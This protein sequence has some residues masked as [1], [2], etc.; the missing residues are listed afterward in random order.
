MA[1]AE[2]RKANQ[3]VYDE[4]SSF[5]TFTGDSDV[6]YDYQYNFRRSITIM[7]SSIESSL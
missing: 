3:L 7:V 4:M 1:T 5:G 2:V 6:L